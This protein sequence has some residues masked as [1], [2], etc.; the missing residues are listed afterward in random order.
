VT[1]HDHGHP[2][3]AAQLLHSAPYSEKTNFHDLF[4]LDSCYYNAYATPP[5]RG[6]SKA[7]SWFRIHFR[8]N[9]FESAPDS[10]WARKQKMLTL[11]FLIGLT[12]LP[13]NQSV[14]HGTTPRIKSKVMM[15]ERFIDTAIE[16]I[17]TS[18]VKKWYMVIS[19]GR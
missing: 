14:V 18:D 15:Q 16:Y 17:C 11:Y 6:A 2:Q 7:L 1:D 19:I 8:V 5:E 9:A 13:L 12:C 4:P 10:L 3:K